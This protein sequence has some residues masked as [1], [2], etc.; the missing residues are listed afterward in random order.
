MADTDNSRLFTRMLQDAGFPVTAEDM[1][2]RWD[3][4]NAEQ[5]TQITNSSKWSP[6][7]GLYPPLLR[8]L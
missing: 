6:S 1:Q 3:A 5:G 7:G 4:L 2:A 8:S